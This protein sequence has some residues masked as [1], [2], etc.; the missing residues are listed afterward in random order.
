MQ[1][2][3]V[4]LGSNLPNSTLTPFDVIEKAYR[5]LENESVNILLKSAF[6]KTPAFPLGCGPDFVN[7]AVKL[8]TSLPPRALL[9]HFHD[10]ETDLGRSRS[11][12]WEARTCDIDLIDYNGGVLPDH[13]TF[14]HWY[15]L[16][17]QQQQKVAPDELILPHPRMSERGFVLQPLS[18]IAPDWVH[19]VLG[20]SVRELL[21]ALPPDAL[22]GI[23]RLPD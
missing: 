5:L 12:R 20:Q 3:L 22:K 9:N 19:P 13:P 18:D 21:E 14:R 6:Y 4:A 1:E 8:K 2:C 17:P 15:S 10:V 7:A 16:S 11:T 23:S